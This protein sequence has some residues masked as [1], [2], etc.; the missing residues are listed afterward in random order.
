MGFSKFDQVDYTEEQNKKE[1]LVMQDL[2][3]QYK[4]LLFT[5]AYQMTGSVSDAED[6]VQ[7]VFVKLHDVK[8]EKLTQPKAYLCRM[9]TNRC[10]D[11]LKSARKQREQYFGE[12]LPEPIV[13]QKDELFESVIQGEMLSYAMLVL[14]EKLSPTERAVF[15]LREAFGFEYQAI[16]GIVD[17][18]EANCRQLF[19]RAKGKLQIVSKE[20][21]P[22]QVASK[23]WIRRFVTALEQDNVDLVVSILAKD[24]M[25]VS[26]GGGKAI[27]AVHPI[28]SRES[29]TRFL[30]GL[31]RKAH[32]DEEVLNFEILEINGQNG[33]VIRSAQGI[34]AVVLMHIEGNLI[35][36]LYIVRNPDKLRPFS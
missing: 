6:V 12:W 26:D 33:I 16:A 32:R 28:E 21:L 25:L 3:E 5:L 30:F 29:V 1:S 18:S 19:S 23:E 14:L 4:G 2:Y 10:L 24:A 22:F 31:I 17:K 7:D 35:Y 27:A 13:T 8:L 11:F 9:V 34:E 15:I 36:N 20:S